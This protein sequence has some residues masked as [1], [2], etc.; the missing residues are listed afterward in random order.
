MET[1]GKRFVVRYQAFNGAFYPEMQCDTNV[2]ARLWRDRI[3][4]LFETVE[5]LDRKTLRLVK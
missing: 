1:V 3:K 4:S 2:E 5:I